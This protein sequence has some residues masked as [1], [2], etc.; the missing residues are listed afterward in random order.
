MVDGD[1][2][3]N[4]SCN[5]LETAIPLCLENDNVTKTIR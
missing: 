2:K 3:W 5:L 4:I 1:F